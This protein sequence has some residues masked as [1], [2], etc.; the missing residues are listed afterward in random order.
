MRLLQL[1]G[2]AP[3]IYVPQEQGG[4]VIPPDSGFP[5]RRVLRLTELRWRYCN[6]P[7]HWKTLKFWAEIKVEVKLRPIVCRPV[8]L[9]VKHASGTR[10]QFFFLLEIFFRQLRV[11]YFVAPFL[12]RGRVCNLLLLLVLARAFPLGS[13]SHGTQYLILLSQFL[14][15]SQPGGPGFL[16]KCTNCDM[17]TNF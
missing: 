7:P 4:P 1:G 11:S 10:D 15:L 17:L 13:E 8:Q 9:G 16:G 12:T 14:T 5:F 2:P 6:P 3:R